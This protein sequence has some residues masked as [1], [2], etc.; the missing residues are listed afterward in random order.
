MGEVGAATATTPPP[1]AHSSAPL[2]NPFTAYWGLLII[3]L[4]RSS[5]YWQQK[6]LSFIYGYRGQ[7]A[8]L[9]NP[10]Y[11]IAASFHPFFD[12]Y[13]GSLVGLLYTMPFAISALFAGQ[14]TRKVN[15]KRM[16][17]AVILGMS[18][19]Q[20]GVGLTS[21]FTVFAIFRVLHGMICS[22]INPVCF[23]LVSDLFPEDRKT[24]ANSILSIANFIGIGLSSMS[25][26]LIKA[27]GWRSVYFSM[28]GLGAVCAGALALSVRS[29][30]GM[31][32]GV[33]EV[34]RKVVVDAEVEGEVVEREEER[35][36]KW[37]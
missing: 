2:F 20:F 19:C 18:L 37:T 4:I 8:Q 11:E 9:G 34:E 10:K 6:S 31:G 29:K 33:P 14:L 35:N 7:G 12:Q 28:A 26:L 22:A 3:T 15:R 27:A 16:L 17:I 25:I 32:T 1:T 21:S 36:R 5:A 24:T 30:A 23:S 13:Y